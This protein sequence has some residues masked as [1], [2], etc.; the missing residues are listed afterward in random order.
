MKRKNETHH[1]Q[2]FVLVA[3]QSNEMNHH[4]TDPFTDAIDMIYTNR[5]F[6][7]FPFVS[8]CVCWRRCYWLFFNSHLL[9]EQTDVFDMYSSCNWNV[10]RLDSLVTWQTLQGIFI[11][12]NH[13]LIYI[14]FGS[15][16]VTH[17]WPLSDVGWSSNNIIIRKC[18]LFISVLFN[19][20]VFKRWFE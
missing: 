14:F 9:I 6:S 16:T 20:A 2:L 1:T 12:D 17:C 8:V 4:I 18:L 19:D 5:R 13:C 15:W 3:I 11:K 10:V 7:H